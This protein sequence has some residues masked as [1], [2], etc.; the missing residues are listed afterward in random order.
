MGD[1][2]ANVELPRA[3]S[4]LLTL[5][6][7]DLETCEAAD[8]YTV[9]MGSWHRW[10][11]DSEQCVVCLAGSVIAQTLKVDRKSDSDFGSPLLASV[12]PQLDALDD[13]RRGELV[14]GLETLALDRQHVE[15]AATR[16][17]SGPECTWL[18]SHD[19]RDDASAFKAHLR[20]L[21]SHLDALEL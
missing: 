6:L 17:A 19:Y 2:R 20:T 12:A 10:D 14:R 13:F 21:A 9:D 1:T 5:A 11:A 7:T 16:L 18:A 15:L 3:A 4:Q 8:G